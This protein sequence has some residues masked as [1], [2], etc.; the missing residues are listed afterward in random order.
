MVVEGC[1][2]IGGVAS[3]A[4]VGVDGAVVRKNLFY[5]PQ[6]WVVRILQETRQPGFVRSRNGV[7]SENFVVFEISWASG[8][9]NVGNGTEP[10]TFAFS[11]NYWFCSDDPHRSKPTTPVTEVGGVYGVNPEVSIDAE[12][13]L[14][15]AGTSPLRLLGL[16]SSGRD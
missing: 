1:T 4:F 7:F 16:Y 6:R 2:F 14:R 12:G 15:F 5:K 3:V 11:K 9:F 10:S 8:G 13:R